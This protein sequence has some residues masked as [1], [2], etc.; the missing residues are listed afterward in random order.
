[1]NNNKYY[2]RL[3]NGNY[4][5]VEAKKYNNIYG[6]DLFIFRD[7]YGT[8]ISEGQTGIKLFTGDISPEAQKY[9]INNLGGIEVLK[10]IINDNINKYGL[11]PRYIN[12]I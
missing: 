7:K 10:Q 4:K 6:I 5:Q 3:E 2:I 12:K 9:R 8:N 1:M 11:S